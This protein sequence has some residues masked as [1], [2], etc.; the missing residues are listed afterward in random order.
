MLPHGR[1]LD[2]S[3]RLFVGPAPETL[4]ERMKNTAELVKVK[5]AF[6]WI[7]G[8]DA[9]HLKATTRDGGPVVL[10]AAQ[11]KNLA[12][13]LGR[14]ATVLESLQQQAEDEADN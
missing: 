14:L 11:A 6:A 9:I 7:E 10:T 2:K 13:R 4:P 1:A 8:Q 3:R 5:E 12:E